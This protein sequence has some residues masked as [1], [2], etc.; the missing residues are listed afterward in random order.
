M[1]W[2]P[3]S[4]YFK[5]SN[6]VE[7]Y[8][9]ILLTLPHPVGS[10]NVSK[11][12]A[13]LGSLNTPRKNVGLTKEKLSSISGIL[14]NLETLFS[15]KPVIFQSFNMWFPRVTLETIPCKE[16]SSECKQIHFVI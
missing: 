5:M 9:F 15:G 2:F 11:S 16:N 13:L 12:A 14:L 1:K 6:D 4:L 3:D 10:K 8:K 7:V